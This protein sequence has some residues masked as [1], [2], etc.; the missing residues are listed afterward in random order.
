MSDGNFDDDGFLPLPDVICPYGL[1]YADD[2]KQAAA[3]ALGC[4]VVFVHG[5][6][7]LWGKVPKTALD[8]GVLELGGC[9]DAAV[10]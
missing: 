9:L 10:A 7:L 5:E 1:R 6:M 4:A 3:L 8:A 2:M